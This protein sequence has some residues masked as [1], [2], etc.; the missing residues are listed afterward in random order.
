MK[1]YLVLINDQVDS[2]KW[3]KDE[4][5]VEMIMAGLTLIALEV[6]STRESQGVKRFLDIF[7]FFFWGGGVK[8]L[9]SFVK[10]YTLKM[11]MRQIQISV[12]Y[13]FDVN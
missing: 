4:F 12:C 10:F 6:K 8:N 9:S 1:K 11:G 13:I 5:R 3:I 7:F 2:K